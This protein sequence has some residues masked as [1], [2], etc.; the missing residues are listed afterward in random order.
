MV[1]AGQYT[2]WWVGITLGSVAVA[3]VVVIV[4]VMLT[5]AARIADDARAGA[6][7]LPVVRDNTD[8]LRAAGRIHESAI[9]ILRSV[10]ATRKALTGS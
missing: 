9:S 1:V 6:E 4:A 3:V 7:V 2:D 5:L 8:A 10:R